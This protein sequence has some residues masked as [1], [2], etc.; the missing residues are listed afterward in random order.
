MNDARRNT[1]KRTF[2]AAYAKVGEDRLPTACLV[3]DVSQTGARILLDA[4]AEVPEVFDLHINGRDQLWRVETVWRRG[5]EIGVRLLTKRPC[6]LPGT[7]R[8]PS[9]AATAAVHV[10]APDLRG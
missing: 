8:R 1:R 10:D 3:R 9:A 2:L 5:A 4:T 7:S 6:G